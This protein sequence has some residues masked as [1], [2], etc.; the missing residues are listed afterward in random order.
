MFIL[1]YIY[2]RN[3]TI[4]IYHTGYGDILELGMNEKYS[5]PEGEAL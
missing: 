1:P 4:L 5:T 3:F 2:L